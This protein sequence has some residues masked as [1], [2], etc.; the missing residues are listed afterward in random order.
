MPTASYN[1]FQAWVEY[2]QEGA[3]LESDSFVVFL[4]NSAPVASNSVIADITQITYTNLSSR[5]LTKVTSAQTS[6]TYTLDFNDLTLTSTGGT[7]GPFRYI[8]VFDDTLA[9]DPLVCWFDYGANVTLGD[10]ES[11]LLQ[12]NAS[13][14]YTVA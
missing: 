4:T 13:G 7:T 6:G 11:L 10:G 3:N 8:G 12:F 9:G 14:L 1:K 5:T 2:M